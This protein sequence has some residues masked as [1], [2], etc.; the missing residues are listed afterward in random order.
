MKSDTSANPTKDALCAQFMGREERMLALVRRYFSVEELQSIRRRLIGSG[1][2]GGKAVGMLLARAILKAD[3]DGGWEQMLEP[4]DSFFVGTS[5]FDAFVEH[6]G[7]LDIMREQRSEEGYLSSASR[8]RE[9]FPEGEFPPA[10][11]AEFRKMLDHYG[12]FPIIARSSSLMEDGFGN[13]F[14]GKYDSFFCVNQGPLEQRLR[15]FEAAVRRIYLSTVSDEALQYRLRRGLASREER[16]A[17]LVQRVSGRRQGDYFFPAFAG[18]GISYNTFVWNPSIDPTAGMLRMV[19][20]LGTRAVDRV[21]GDYPRIV[22]L[23]QP[24]LLPMGDQEDLRRF[25]QRD[26]D[27]L[28]IAANDIRT[29]S[30]RELLGQEHRL[31]LELFGNRDV[32]GLIVTFERLLTRTGFSETMRRLLATLENAYGYPVDVEFTG[33]FIDERNLEINIV[34]CRPLQTR[35]VQSMRVEIP[36][37]PDE[38]SLFRSRGSFMGG[39]IVQPLQRVISVDPERYTS[40]TLSDKYELARIIGRLN[41]MIPS[42]EELPTLLMGPGRWGTTTPSLGVPVRFAEFNS[43]SVLAEVAFSAGGLMPELSFGSHFFQDLVESG[44]FYVALHPERRGCFLNDRLLAALPNRLEELLPD[45]A[46]FAGVIRIV[47]LPERFTLLADIVSQELACYRAEPREPEP[48]IPGL[49]LEQP[50]GFVTSGLPGL[51]S[52]LGGLRLGDNVVWRVDRIEDFHDY[53]RPFVS[54]ALA[55][56]RRV[57]YIRFAGHEPLVEDPAMVKVHNLDALRGF[58]SFTVKLH[59]IIGQEGREVFYLFDCLS[60]LLDAWATDAMIGNFFSVTCPYLFELDTVAYFPLIRGTHPFTTIARIRSTTQLLLDL[61][62]FEGKSILHPLKVWRRFSPTMFLPHRHQGDRFE[63]VKASCDASN[64]FI[65]LHGTRAEKA[66]PHI[67]HWEWLFMK[68]RKLARG[69]GSDRSRQVMVDNLCRL[70]FGSDKRMLALARRH[71]TLEDFLWIKERMIGTGYIGGKAAGMVV[72]RA[73]LERDQEFDWTGVLE[74]HDSFFIGSDLF[75]TYLVHNGWWKV[76]M[77]HKSPEGYLEGAAKLRKLLLLGSFPTGICEEFQKLLEYFGQYPIIVRLS[78]LQ[79][80]GFGNAF[81]GKYG[82]FF[83]VNQGTPEERYCQFEEAVRLA[84]A[85]TMSEDALQYRLQRG[86]DQQEEQMALLVQRVAGAYHGRYFFPEIAGVGLSYNTFV[87]DESVDPHAGMLRL[88]FGLGTRAT[89]RVAGDYTRIVSLDH[90]AMVPFGTPESCQRF[91]Q[92]QIDLLDI[93]EN[94]CR[95]MPIATLLAEGVPLP[96]VYRSYGTTLPRRGGSGVEKG[97]TFD[98]LLSGQDF[99]E[100]MGRLL[101]TLERAYDYP[102]DVEFTA[103]SSWSG[104]LRINLVQCRPLQTRGVQVRRVEIP[105]DLPEDAVLFR[106]HGHFLGGSIHMPIRRVIHIPSGAFLALPLNERYEIARIVGRLNRLAPSREELPTLLMAPGRLGTTT[107]EMGV[108]VRFAEIDRMAAL[109]EL[110]F[111]AGSLAPELSFGS[112][113]FQDLVESGIFYVAVY[114]EEKGCMTNEQLLAKLPNRLA[115][116]LPDDAGFAEYVRVVDLAGEFRL[117]ADIVSQ[118]VIC[119]K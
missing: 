56:G 21:E 64:L 43:V 72:A 58:E 5:V 67:D 2:I 97:L 74:P 62:R 22:S 49:N 87:W 10:I 76:F 109:A 73:I 114:P 45:D 13:A 102:V 52:V 91:S 26:V 110:S 93:E 71:V 69:K 113:F 36:P 3:R 99:P 41:R 29:I 40:L 20:G 8:L 11:R 63:P 53:A 77:E 24:M 30:L 70:L 12:Q 37:R 84:Y 96:E 78:S 81:A 61:H 38:E 39:S 34:Q 4:H 98:R 95:T 106:S 50:A 83:C 75:H 82:S 57:V 17:I 66:V 105:G 51:D 94:E 68:A 35:G 101:A 28:D 1:F 32:S 119:C 16:M 33:N 80:D 55:S 31:P 42:R 7:W 112:H 48:V 46:R 44:I 65:G 60:S 100:I 103:T 117:M 88:V 115:D 25:T 92:R 54:S 19:V 85:S 104:G 79:E 14:A 108:P 6:N 90:P 18:V 89:A 107:P 111:S 15:Q 86:L 47:D 23:D 27:L 9:L 116:L 59:E 118:G